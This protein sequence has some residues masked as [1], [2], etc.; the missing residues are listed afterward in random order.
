MTARQP[1]R[2]RRNTPAAA[3]PRP[4]AEA[5]SAVPELAAAATRRATRAAGPREHHVTNDYRYVRT[6]LLTV[7]AVGIIVIAF[8]AVMSFIV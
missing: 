7:A 2:T 3:L 4:V 5:E 6:D 8:V 1:R